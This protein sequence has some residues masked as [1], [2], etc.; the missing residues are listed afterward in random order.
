MTTLTPTHNKA[1]DEIYSHEKKD[2]GFL[3]TQS[4]IR[5]IMNR[6]SS[7]DDDHNSTSFP[8]KRKDSMC[9]IMSENLFEEI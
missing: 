1:K 9:S 6:I 4:T 7:D 8:K 2:Q 5:Q 3:Q